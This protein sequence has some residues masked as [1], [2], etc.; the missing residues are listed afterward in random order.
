MHKSRKR[1]TRSRFAGEKGAAP[2][3][4]PFDFRV[5]VFEELRADRALRLRLAVRGGDEP[6]ALL[7]ATL[8]GGQH[9][10]AI[11]LG[12]WGHGLRVGLR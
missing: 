6:P 5:T 2:F 8:G 3:L 10:L 11:A 4:E 12:Q 9:M 7:D 1:L